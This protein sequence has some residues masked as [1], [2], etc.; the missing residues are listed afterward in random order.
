MEAS[1]LPNDFKEFLQSLNAERVEYLLIGGYAVGYYGYPR[2]TADIDF[3]IARRQDNAERV[4]KALKQFGFDMPE[5]ELAL[6][7]RERSVARMG[8]PPMRIEITNYIDGV[9]FDECYARR[10]VDKIDGVQVSLI[11]LDDLKTNKRAV[12]RLKDLADLE[13]LP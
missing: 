3:W 13:N 4:V 8:V 10:V 2:Y 9:Q 11:S 7:M 1:T 6:F 12:G 5:N